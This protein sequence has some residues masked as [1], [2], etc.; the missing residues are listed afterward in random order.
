MMKMKKFMAMALSALMIAGSIAVLPA[1]A[2][3]SNTI[4][5][6]GSKNRTTYVGK[7]LEL[8]VREGYEVKD[9]HMKWSVGNST[10]LA[11][12][13][14][15]RYGDDVELRALKTGTTTVTC[16]NLLTGGKIT[17]NV[18]VKAASN[19]ISRIGNKNRT[20]DVGDEFELAVKKLGTISDSK[21]K[22]T[23]GNTSI[24]RFDDDDRYGDDM[25]FR[26]LK[27]GTTTITCKN[28]LTGGKIEFK[29]TVK[30]PSATYTIS[31]VGSATRTEEVDDDFELRVKKS[32]ALKS[33]QIKWFIADTS[34]LRFEDGDCYGTEVELEALRTGTTKVTATNLYTGG[35]IVYTIK[36]VPE[37]DD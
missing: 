23:I 34:I 4:S 37:Y 9:R 15:D 2:A 10:I 5:R 26:A 28:L 22:W 13:D 24:V 33:S 6:V 20:Y 3:S 36:V 19:K 18:T 32:S 27:A 16:K 7:E 11:F 8:E 21:L 12:E 25:E 14:N 29:V 30:K 1:D 35:K 17:Y 31:R